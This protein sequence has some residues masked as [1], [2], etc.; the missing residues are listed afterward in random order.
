MYEFLNIFIHSVF[1]IYKT[2][3]QESTPGF[4]S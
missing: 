2:Y 4:L 3:V 1:G